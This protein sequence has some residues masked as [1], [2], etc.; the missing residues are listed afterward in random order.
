MG[1]SPRGPGARETRGAHLR[2]RPGRRPGPGPR[3]GAPHPGSAGGFHICPPPCG[4][5]APRF[6]ASAGVFAPRPRRERS[7][8]A[9]VGSEARLG[10]ESLALGGCGRRGAGAHWESSQAS[11]G[12]VGGRRRVQNKGVHSARGAS[13]PRRKGVGKHISARADTAH[14][15][16]SFYIIRRHSAQLCNKFENPDRTELWKI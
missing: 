2:G 8:A 1:W 3:S 5:R 16:P 15:D 6:P 9:W 4:P 7:P 12:N 11:P 14:T 10:W 13:R